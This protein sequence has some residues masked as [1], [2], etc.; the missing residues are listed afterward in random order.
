MGVAG[1]FGAMGIMSM[2]NAYAQGLSQKTQAQFTSTQ[3]AIN[4]EVA[5]EQANE[6]RSKGDIEAG[7]MELQGRQEAAKQ[8]VA[9]AA[10]GADVNSGSALEL[11]SDTAWQSMQNQITIKNNAWRQA[12]GYDMQASDYG[13]E[14]EFYGMAGSNAMTN[15][16]LTGGLQ[17]V[18]YGVQAGSAYYKYKG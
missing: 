13:L 18:G 3:Y 2:G 9:E 12:W 1:G 15:T 5:G 14:S 6:E 4:K 8:R 7:Q 10:T 17:A 11:Q 16:L